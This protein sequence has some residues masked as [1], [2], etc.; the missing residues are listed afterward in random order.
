MTS[1]SLGWGGFAEQEVRKQG[2]DRL[3]L[4]TT[5]TADWFEQRGFLPAGPAHM[6]TQLP[7]ARRKLVRPNPK[8]FSVTP[9]DVL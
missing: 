5:R 4:L 3:V 7:E 9:K 1:D 6:S 8:A 2:V